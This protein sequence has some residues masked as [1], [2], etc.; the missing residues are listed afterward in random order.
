MGDIDNGAASDVK[1]MAE[2]MKAQA[3]EI[4]R[5]RMELQRTSLK[6][7]EDIPELTSGPFEEFV[8]EERVTQWM[9]LCVGTLKEFLDKVGR[10]LQR[11][12]DHGRANDRGSPPPP[13][14]R[15]HRARVRD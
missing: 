9:C 6:Q 15:D 11:P 1:S 2:A 14:P 5:P 12:T 4:Q 10:P 8:Q 13:P 7:K 3:Q